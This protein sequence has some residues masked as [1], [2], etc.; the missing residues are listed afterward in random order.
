MPFRMDEPDYDET[1]TLSGEDA[2]EQ[3]R[4]IRQRV[5]EYDAMMGANRQ[6]RPTVW[7]RVRD[8]E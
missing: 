7:Q 8:G 1:E 3:I 6:Q 2:K 5:R 4:R